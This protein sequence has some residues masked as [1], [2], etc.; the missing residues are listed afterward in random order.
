MIELAAEKGASSWLTLLPNEEHGFHLNKTAFWDAIHM[1]YGWKLERMP[2]KCICG[3]QFSVEDALTCP[4]SSFTFIRHNEIRYLTANLLSELCRLDI[5]AHGF[6]N[7]GVFNPHASSNRLPSPGAC[8]RKHERE[9][10]R[11]YEERIREVEHGSFTPL[12]F[13]ATGGMDISVR[14]ST[15]DL[16]HNQR[17][18]WTM[19]DYA[20]M[21]GWIR[22][23]ISFS[24]IQSAVMC[25]KG[26]R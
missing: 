5:Q 20:T 22:C 13:S 15:N 23:C 14:S 12:V 4:G 6:C 7:I 21:T 16:H 24:L 9:K 3:A 8:Y 2:D 18:E 11:K 26:S 17:E 1:R 25:V 10:R 19:K